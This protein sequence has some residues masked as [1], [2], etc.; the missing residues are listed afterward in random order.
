MDKDRQ[1][2]LVRTLT[3]HCLKTACPEKLATFTEDFAV[4]AMSAGAPR[5]A[6]DL[7]QLGPSQPGLE[8]TLVAGMFFQVLLEAENLPAKPPERVAFIRKEAK[9]YLVTRLAGQIS[10]SQFFRLL[11]LIEENAQRYFEHLDGGWLAPRKDTP[12]PAPRAEAEVEVAES[13]QGEALR[14]ALSQI[15]LLPKGRRKL[16]HET[17][18][19]FFRDTRGEWFRLLDFEA[20]FRINKKT[21]WAYLNLLHKAGILDHNHEKANKVRYI[22]AAPFRRA[23][24]PPRAFFPSSS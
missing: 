16:T 6:E 1:L 9:N 23:E 7:R 24:A 13:I 14:Q 21:A 12:V 22:L 5:A 19:E 10:L 8:T 15:P 4:F 3:W 17:L 2:E 11:N 20:R 18:W